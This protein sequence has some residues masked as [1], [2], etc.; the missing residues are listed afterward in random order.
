MG[1]A[2]PGIESNTLRGTSSAKPLSRCSLP[3]D[4][5]SGRAG[6]RPVL[7]EPAPNARIAQPCLV[8]AAVHHECVGMTQRERYC[9]GLL[10]GCTVTAREPIS[11]ISNPACT[12]EA[13]LPGPA[14]KPLPSP[15]CP[16]GEAAIPQRPREQC[17]YR[18]RKPIRSVPCR[19]SGRRA[20]RAKP[21]VGCADSV[22]GQCAGQS[23]AQPYSPVLFRKMRSAR[24]PRESNK[25]AEQR[26]PNT[27]EAPAWT[28][29]GKD[30]S[31][32]DRYA[33]DILT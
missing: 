11:K 16:D 26:S 1:R 3:V 27:T 20:C 13:Y 28:T 14:R 18:Q 22:P 8:W 7:G 19:S 6:H 25:T 30:M 32:S 2:Q 9:A 29:N 4:K 12:Q 17:R 15:S 24:R 21:A 10:H 31:P 33:R 23:E 5:Q